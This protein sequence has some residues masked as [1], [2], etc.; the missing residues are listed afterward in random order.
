MSLSSGVFSHF[1]RLIFTVQ[2]SD[3]PDR[4]TGRN[5]CLIELSWDGEREL[6]EIGGT[7]LEDGD[8]VTMEAWVEG[9]NG[10]RIGFGQL[11]TKVQPAD[12]A[13]DL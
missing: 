4:S 13:E 1:W 10:K 6:P 8:Q 5:G 9:S 2:E 12:G 3:W 11:V 7:F